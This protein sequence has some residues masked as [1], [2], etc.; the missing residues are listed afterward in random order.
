MGDCNR[1]TR[2]HKCDSF[3]P[4]AKFKVNGYFVIYNTLVGELWSRFS[5]F[6]AMVVPFNCLIPGHMHDTKTFERLSAMFADDVDEGISKA[7]YMQILS[8]L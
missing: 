6:Q 4:A 7:E 8:L 5:D 3:D 2:L 1:E